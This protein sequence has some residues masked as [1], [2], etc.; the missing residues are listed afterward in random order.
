MPRSKNTQRRIILPDVVY[1][2]T[3]VTRLINRVMKDGEKAVA[4]RLVYNALAIVEKQTRRKPVEIL[5]EAVRNI[6]PNM[7][8]RSRRV[9]GSNYQV[10]MPVRP[11]R[12]FSLAIRWLIEESRKRPNAQ[13]HTYGEK[14]AAEILDAIENTGNAV[15]K[16][17]TMH[18]SA[19]ANKAFAHFRW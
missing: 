19:E 1:N 5:E 8:V 13:Y 18:R 7:E 10:P 2:S 14:L 9:G 12:S 15:N 4:E 3:L 17:L 6:G 16:K 11:H